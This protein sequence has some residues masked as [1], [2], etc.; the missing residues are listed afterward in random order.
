MIHLPLCATIEGEVSM[1]VNGIDGR[2]FGKD[3]LYA[4]QSME[5][6]EN[7]ANYANSQL[8]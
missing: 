2:K 6:M 7:E 8:T 4:G 1:E 5:K 3:T